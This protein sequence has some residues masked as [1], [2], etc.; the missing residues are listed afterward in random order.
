MQV[1]VDES[2][3]ELLQLGT[4]Q[5]LDVVGK[6]QVESAKAFHLIDFG[7][8]A[9]CIFLSHIKNLPA[10]EGEVFVVGD[11]AEL[12]AEAAWRPHTLKVRVVQIVATPPQDHQCI[13]NLRK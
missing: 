10:V 4:V 6:T 1:V 2:G 8:T 12:V 9:Y 5:D 7:A 13:F 11:V 3:H